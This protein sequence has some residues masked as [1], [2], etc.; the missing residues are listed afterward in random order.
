M[1]K[2]RLHFKLLFIALVKI[3]AA[4]DL[5]SVDF[6]AYT[7][8]MKCNSG[9]RPYFFNQSFNLPENTLYVR[10]LFAC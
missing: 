6:T 3:C 1:D 2:F 10:V 5:R 7:M 8:A 9:F 4:T